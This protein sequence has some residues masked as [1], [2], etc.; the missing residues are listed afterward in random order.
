MNGKLKG[1][2]LNCLAPY[3]FYYLPNCLVTYCL[4]ITGG[5]SFSSIA[6]VGFTYLVYELNL[7]SFLGVSSASPYWA[8]FADL[9]GTLRVQGGRTVS[10]R[11]IKRASRRQVEWFLHT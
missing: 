4:L 1:P 10:S 3:Q 6:Y 8:Y 9:A 11:L 2:H 7:V 5:P